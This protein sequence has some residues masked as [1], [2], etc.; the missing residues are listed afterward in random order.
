MVSKNLIF[1]VFLGLVACKEPGRNVQH[2]RFELPSGEYLHIQVLDDNLVHFN[3]NHS[4]NLENQNLTSPSLAGQVYQ[5]PAFWKVK[6]WGFETRNLRVK[7]DTLASTLTFY[8]KK[9]G[10][11]LL[12]TLHVG[13]EGSRYQLT[14]T[15]LP[16]VQV[17]GLGQ[18]FQ[19]THTFGFDHNGRKRQGGTYG[20][21]MIYAY[22]AN[23][24]GDTQI[25]IAYFLNGP[26]YDNYA[27]FLDVSSK[28]VW[29]FTEEE[30]YS[31]HWQNAS[32]E[33][34]FF[35]GE[36]LPHLRRQ[37]MT[38]TG[39]PPLPS[40]Q[41]FGLW[42]SEYGYESWAELDSLKQGLT[43]RG[44][45][46]SGFM[47]DLQWFG[48]ID[49]AGGRM[50]GLDW[51]TLNFPNP[52]SKL[53]EY[54]GQGIGII[55]IEEP[56][57]EAS[58][59]DYIAYAQAGILARHMRDTSN[60]LLHINAWWGTGGMFDYTHPSTASHIYQKKRKKLAL[61]GV[62]GHWLDLGEPETYHDSTLYYL[63][64]PSLVHNHYAMHW[65]KGIHQSYMADTLSQRF[66]LLSRSGGAGM[67]RF[68]AGLWSGD[69]GARLEYL[70]EHAGAQANVSFSGVDYYGSDIGGFHRK[71]WD[72]QLFNTTHELND[73]YTRWFAYGA[74][75][76]V[77]VRPHVSNVDPKFDHSSSPHLV[78]HLA[79]NLHNI[80]LRY[81]LI[82]YIYSVAWQAYQTGEAVFPPL[83]YY[84]QQD[85][86]VYNRG[87]HKMIGPFLLGVSNFEYAAKEQEVYLP[88]GGWFNWYTGRYQMGGDV[89]ICALYEKDIFRLPL[90]AKAGAILPM[91]SEGGDLENWV[92]LY[93]PESTTNWQWYADDGYSLA[94]QSGDF[95]TFSIVQKKEKGH[96]KVSLLPGNGKFT[97][98]G[99]WVFELVGIQKPQ[100][101]LLNGSRVPE[102]LVKSDWEQAAIGLFKS[103]SEVLV[104][105]P[106]KV[107]G[108][109]ELVIR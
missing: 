23:A 67:Q 82:P 18:H 11:K 34:Y 81:A 106:R 8:D 1:L 24:T 59:P 22:D 92:R 53:A 89:I 37:Y 93:E 63:G 21:E 41:M 70:A 90:F 6:K 52:A 7:M 107:N 36:D 91:A 46:L 33:A 49:K 29:D 78:G 108:K 40:R 66:F 60:T 42:M 79:S 25:P 19:R 105:V 75:F 58:L 97:V 84:Y 83:V 98:S 94:Y 45:P 44:F 101:V 20:N 31:V 103:P 65:M 95:T 3:W 47:L 86:Q 102:F 50:G 5:G 100:H 99:N 35:Y 14:G 61:A 51:D 87:N 54:S 109:V 43:K 30:S 56:Y 88:E 96:W 13:R 104:K 2:L 55:P 27:L 69:I 57:V 16:Q 77:P 71:R 74:L 10:G 32:P 12:T 68:G 76:D 72:G 62:S 15:C 9:K 38:L 80:R 39:R 73:M 28:Q 48:G 64:G 17:Y 26:G 85:E 4:S